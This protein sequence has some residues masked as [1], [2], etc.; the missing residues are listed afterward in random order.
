MIA[1]I[2]RKRYEHM[3]KYMLVRNVKDKAIREEL[4]KKLNA[5]RMFPWIEIPASIAIYKMRQR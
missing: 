3:L 1:R 2:E 4:D 5:D